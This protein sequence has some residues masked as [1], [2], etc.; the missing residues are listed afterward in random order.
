[1]FPKPSGSILT[2]STPNREVAAGDIIVLKF[3]EL[4]PCT[5]SSLS[6]LP[7][8]PLPY[9]LANLQCA[10]STHYLPPSAPAQASSEPVSSSPGSAC[11]VPYS[12][13]LPVALPLARSSAEVTNPKYIKV[14]TLFPFSFLQ[15]SRHL[16]PFVSLVPKSH[17]PLHLLKPPYG[18]D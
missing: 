10:N 4:Y 6:H 12:T 5:G 14:V 9:P 1:M 7:F 3:H 2:H 16:S 13:Q 11:H 18:E 8:S 15:T 17:F